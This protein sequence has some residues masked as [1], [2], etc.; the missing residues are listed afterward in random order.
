MPPHARMSLAQ[1]LLLRALVARFWREPYAAGPTRLTRWG[2]ELHDRFLLPH[3][4][5]RTSTT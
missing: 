1:Q 5:Q 3:F 4:V 2:T